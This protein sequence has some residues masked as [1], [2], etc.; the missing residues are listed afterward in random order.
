MY[1]LGLLLL[2]NQTFFNII[3]RYDMLDSGYVSINGDSLED[4]N[5]RQL[6]MYRRKHL[7][8]VFQM[9]SSLQH[10]YVKRCHYAR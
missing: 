7:G 5:E 8:Y 10:Y 1:F 9:Q 3:R 2:V 4:M 6:T